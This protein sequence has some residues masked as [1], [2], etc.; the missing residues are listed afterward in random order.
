MKKHVVFMVHGLGEQVPGDT[1][2]EFVGAAC[3][4]LELTGPVTNNT[5]N[6]VNADET[7]EHIL[8]TE[9]SSTRLLTG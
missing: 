3:K 1:V 6:L 2:D 9:S 5:L 8:Y 4:E 7:K